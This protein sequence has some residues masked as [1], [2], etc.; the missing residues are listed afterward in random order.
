MQVIDKVNQGRLGKINFSSCGRDNRGWIIK[1]Q[2]L[3]LRY[4]IALSELPVVK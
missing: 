3:S 4:T 1:L 2:Q